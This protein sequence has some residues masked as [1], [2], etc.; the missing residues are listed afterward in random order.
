MDATPITEMME[1]L[2]ENTK[3]SKMDCGDPPHSN[4]LAMEPANHK[5]VSKP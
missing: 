1:T 5:I 2:V 3:R 4:H